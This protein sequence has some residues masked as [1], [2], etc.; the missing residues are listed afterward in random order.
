LTGTLREFTFTIF[1]AIFAAS[2]LVALVGTPLARRTALRLDIV[3]VPNTERKQHQVPMPYLGG[4]AIYA[5]FLAIVLIAVRAIGSAEVASAEVLEQLLA[6][7]GG[8]TTMA[9]LGLFDDRYNLPALLRLGLQCLAA[10]VLINSGVTLHFNHYP[11]L[12]GVVSFLWIVGLTNAFNLLDNMDGLSVGVAAIAAIYFFLLAY[13]A[14]PTQFLVASLSAALAGACLGFLRY[15]FNPARI[16]MG[17][18]GAYFLG[19]LLAAIGMKLRIY[20]GTGSLH[21]VTWLIPIVVL[22]LPIFDTTMVTIS[23]L[24]RGISPGTGGRD[25][26]SHRLVRAGMTTRETVMTLY[27]V[28]CALG[29]GSLVLTRATFAEGLALGGVL[30]VLGVLA[31]LYMERIYA[32]PP[33]QPALGGTSRPASLAQAGPPEIAGTPLTQ[34]PKDSAPV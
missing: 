6:I 16:F 25:H 14:Q 28:C 27:L 33:R 1:M 30:I 2:L 18:A 23:R 31:F 13:L 10:L 24:R 26:T 11:Q 32:A 17:D 19:F 29:T 5:A 15:N 20:L 7:L 8:A 9:V 3:D 4:V 34:Q 21:A 22:G 12:D